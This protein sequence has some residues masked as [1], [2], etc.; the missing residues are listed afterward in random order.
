VSNILGRL[1][2]ELGVNTASFLTGMNAA[3][4]EAKKT[5][6]DI[7]HAFDAVGSS[8]GK[9]LGSFGEVG[10]KFG[11]LGSAASEMLGVIGGGAG[12]LGATI[13]LI[14]G[15]GIAAVGA[16]AGL[17]ALAIEGA[18]IVERFALISQ[19]TGIG[20]RDLQT[21]EAAGKTVGVSLEDMVT[22]MRKFDQAIVGTG[23]NSSA[24][25]RVLKEL[26]ITSHDNNE[27]LLQAADAFKAM[28]DG[29]EKAADAVSLFGRAG[30]NMIPFLNKGREGVEEFNKIVAE[31][32]PNITKHGVEANEEW[33]VSTVKLSLAW[34]SFAVSM[35]EHV[36]PA[37][38]AVVGALA[39]A[40]HGTGDFVSGAMTGANKLA[41]AALAYTMALAMG[42]GNGS[43]IA[44]A[45]F[46]IDKI[47]RKDHPEDS[48]DE[49]KGKKKLTADEEKFIALQ[50]EQYDIAKAGGEAEYALA[51][52]RE[53][54][55][56]EVAK[57][58]YQIA[59]HILKD[60]IPGLEKAAQ[61]EKERNKH[62]LV[63]P[64]APGVA[65]MTAD[66]LGSLGQ[67]AEEQLKLAEATDHAAGS[68]TVLTAEMQANKKIGDDLR[69]L[70]DERNKLAKELQ[71]AGTNVSERDRQSLSIRLK[72]IDDEKSRLQAAAPEITR[73]YAQI[74]VAKQIEQTGIKLDTTTDTNQQHIDSLRLL[75]DAYAEGGDAIN[76][77]QI[78]QKL[79][80]E[81]I[82]LKKSAEA[83]NEYAVEF[84]KDTAGIARMTA[85]LDKQNKTL[86]LHRQQLE[87]EK[88]LTIAA[89]IEKDTRA[90]EGEI[91]AYDL[92][93]DA[94]D[95]GA[96]AKRQAEAE[97]AFAK[98]KA[99]GGT[100]D[101]A[102]F[103]KEK[104]LT[105]SEEVRRKTVA[106]QGA[107]LDLN[108]VYTDQRD[109]IGEISE[110][111]KGN[112]TVQLQLSAQLYDENNRLNSQW[113][114][115]AIK[116][117]GVSD[118]LKAMLD[119]IRQ[120]GA[121]PWE[122]VFTAMSK[123]VNDLT[124]SLANFIVTGKGSLQ[125]IE[126][127]FSVSLVKT[128][129]QTLESKAAGYLEN[130]FLG[131]A[132]GG[133]PDGT[134]ANPLHVK[135]VGAGGMGADGTSD[136]GLL[137]AVAGMKQPDFGGFGDI[138]AGFGGGDSL[139]KPDGT[140][141]KP[142]Y[143]ADN[144]GGAGGG[145]GGGGGLFGGLSSLF[146]GGGSSD[147]FSAAENSFLDGGPAP[148][149]GGGG[150][151]GFFSGIA[152]AL[153][154]GFR[155][156]GGDVAAGKAYVVGENHPE[157]FVPGKSGSVVPSVSTG[158]ET[159]VH[160]QFNISTPDA[161][162]FRRSHAQIAA[163]ASRM[164]NIALSRS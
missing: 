54:V 134:E 44:A 120:G 67:Q 163:D 6:S 9:A 119:Q 29:P 41:S 32:G 114:A 150:G 105:L 146:S 92:L 22:A 84:P 151:G 112:A 28:A 101:E 88:A 111:Y 104:S 38:T 25:A 116:V 138:L 133:K 130:K 153:F 122:Q 123:T 158:Q 154:G 91:A 14:A 162:S 95:R 60:E 108:R 128:G 59:T 164:A 75:A 117:G 58:H 70:D 76:R 2:V 87:Q 21:L 63:A 47:N 66:L 152:S 110:K 81:K 149:E 65:P 107:A 103:A 159:H 85:D 131:G 49:G 30:L 144:S 100:D 98:V 61:L 42:Q 82:A 64:K 157:I 155:A 132:I 34:D 127:Q 10:S 94:A 148:D 161:D 11:E 56:N 31:F 1:L 46:Q 73:L 27:A 52:A 50:R 33:K 125:Q 5:A 3:S 4:K 145:L 37:L 136:A 8:V 102:N 86:T 68:F 74:A 141:S 89:N 83:L 20:I 147:G 115:A 26:G 96:E 62:K 135:D 97:G 43:A 16:A 143:V 118:K 48:G 13:G 93:I 90:L 23:K 109:L 7:E 106:E 79:D 156:G 121:N 99:S 160:Q 39:S 126:Q 78:E 36:L 77:A 124:D 69:K 71:N 51:Q 80:G 35:E 18:E 113:D 45:S 142:F 24:T 57:E 17:S 19:K 139:G 15:V 40:T 72:Q 129:L 55:T 53:R 137:G 12:P 140:Q